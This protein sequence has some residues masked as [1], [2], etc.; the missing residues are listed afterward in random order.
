MRQ[1]VNSEMIVSVGYDEASQVL[2]IEFQR[3]HRVYRYQ[4]VPQ[5]LY[6]GLLAAD[7]KGRF[8]TRRI[9]G[10]YATEQV[11]TE[12]LSRGSDDAAE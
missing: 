10:R 3:R 4:D 6:L 9:A 12:T 1:N 11:T 7:S 2:E 5:F 8:F